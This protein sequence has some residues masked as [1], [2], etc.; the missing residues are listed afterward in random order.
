M[1]SIPV[2]NST[3]PNEDDVGASGAPIPFI[4]AFVIVLV[5]AVFFIVHEVKLQ[6]H[7]R[8][9]QR[10]V[11]STKHVPKETINLQTLND[12]NPSQ[13]YQQVKGFK[14]QATWASTQSNSAEVCVICLEVLVD[15]DDVRQL[16]CKHVFHSTCIDSWFQKYRVD[17]PLCKSIFIPNRQGDPIPEEVR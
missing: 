2:G 4:V 8:Q 5:L 14:R 9:P 10:D 7:R 3:R 12:A 13:K 17:C 16:K 6:S 15:Q 1:N 11:E